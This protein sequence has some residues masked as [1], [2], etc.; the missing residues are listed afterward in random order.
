MVDGSHRA[1]K[2][3]LFL[4]TL[5]D[6][7]E[8]LSDRAV[9][10]KGARYHRLRALS[11]QAAREIDVYRRVLLHPRTPRIARWCLAAA[12]VYFVMP[13]DLIPDFIPVTWSLR[14]RG[15]RARAGVG[16]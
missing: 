16:G 8:P 11:Q 3:D 10:V 6:H 7:G 2:V 15:D 12:V 13:I 9:A 14:R 5:A 1:A 4:K